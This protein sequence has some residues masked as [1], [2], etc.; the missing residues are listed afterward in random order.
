MSRF[1]GRSI[2]SCSPKSYKIVGDD[3]LT[4]GSNPYNGRFL[5]SQAEPSKKELGIKFFNRTNSTL[6]APPS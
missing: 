5:D 3:P 4:I 1:Y 6:Q 2:Q